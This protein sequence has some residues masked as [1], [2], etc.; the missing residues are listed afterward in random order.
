VSWYITFA[1]SPLMIG[2]NPSSRF[3]ADFKTKHWYQGLLE[4]N[5]RIG[6]T[7]PKF[8]PKGA[9][10]LQLMESAE[11]FYRSNHTTRK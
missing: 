1:Q 8:D 11:I 4:P 5:F 7:D 3:A 9:L 2:Y 6:R 10:T